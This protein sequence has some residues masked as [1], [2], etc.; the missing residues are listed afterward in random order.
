VTGTGGGVSI[1]TPTHEFLAPSGVQKE[2]LAPGDLFVAARNPNGS[3]LTNCSTA[4]SQE[5]APPV[6]ADD[7][8]TR[9][10]VYVRTPA[11]LKPSACTPLF[12]AAFARGAGACIHTHS[13]WA[14]LV[15]LLLERKGQR[16]F[17][18]EE[19]EQIKGIRRGRGK[20]GSLGYFDRL[21]VPVIENTARL[22]WRES[23]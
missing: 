14:V 2:R 1:A 20:Q 9:G 5:P 15:T 7:D 13:Q 10:S 22:V 17:E 11:H 18:I 12:R 8:P 23:W 3:I 4:P 21:R 19:L 6:R 16:V